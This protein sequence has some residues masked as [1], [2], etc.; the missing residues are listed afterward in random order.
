MVH[1]T[2]LASCDVQ[3]AKAQFVISIV[4]ENEWGTAEAPKL[5]IAP[6]QEECTPAEFENMGNSTGEVKAVLSQRIALVT[7]NHRCCVS[8]DK[9]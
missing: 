9:T 8:V 4:E 1:Q 7:K 3:P 2:E 5:L 6:E